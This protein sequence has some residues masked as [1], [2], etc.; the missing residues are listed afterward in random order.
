MPSPQ[1]PHAG[2]QV[3]IVTSQIKKEPVLLFP[4]NSCIVPQCCAGEAKVEMKLSDIYGLKTAVVGLNPGHQPFFCSIYQLS[5]VFQTPPA[6]AKG[7]S[8]SPL[9]LHWQ[10]HS[11]TSTD[12]GRG[13]PYAHHHYQL[14]ITTNLKKTFPP[15]LFLPCAPCSHTLLFSAFVS[16]R[17]H[18]EVQVVHPVPSRVPPE[19]LRV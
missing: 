8:S 19:S 10:A 15:A 5:T 11:I 2:F 6:L 3:L 14:T 13:H 16:W 9:P 12:Y 4:I 7:I 18:P 17:Y 1:P